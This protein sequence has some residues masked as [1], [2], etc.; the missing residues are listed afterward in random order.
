MQGKPAD[1]GRGD[2]SNG[3]GKGKNLGLVIDV[4]ERR[5]SF[6][7]RDPPFG[8]HP[9]AAHSREIDHH[10]SFGYGGTCHVVAAPTHGNLE[11]V[12]T[13]KVDRCD[14]IRDSLAPD[15]EP[16]TLVDQTVP[17]PARLL[18]IG[19]FRSDQIPAQRAL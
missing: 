4:P 7:V 11:V 6:D 19:V 3:Y 15:D 5:T 12:I 17:N 8:V 14:D 16:R 18:V 1:A 2:D 9:D 10:A 13:G